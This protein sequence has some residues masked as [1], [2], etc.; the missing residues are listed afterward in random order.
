MKNDLNKKKNFLNYII[1]IYPIL[2]ETDRAIIFLE[3]MQD[4]RHL[5]SK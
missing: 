5:L 3:F 2:T 1:A 4:S